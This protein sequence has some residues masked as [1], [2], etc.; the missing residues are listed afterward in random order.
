MDTG[1]TIR[2]APDGPRT[3]FRAY[4]SLQPNRM[5]NGIKA[6]SLILN[7]LARSTTAHRLHGVLPTSLTPIGE[8]T[9]L[10]LFLGKQT[11]GHRRDLE[12]VGGGLKLDVRPANLPVRVNEAVLRE[13]VVALMDA[14][15][16]AASPPAP[17]TIRGIERETGIEL[18]VA[19]PDWNPRWFFQQVREWDADR[20]PRSL[21]R[22]CWDRLGATFFVDHAPP[23]GSRV[24]L[25][26]PKRPPVARFRRSPA[27]I[28]HETSPQP[29]AG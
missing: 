6:L 22:I 18:S 21:R 14:L 26:L 1:G 5:M 28:K 16:P 3:E 8:P 29:L 13:V 25:L 2:P 20:D 11:I 19:H 9:R 24:G 7:P 15:A 10:A 17:V 23:D 12:F 4:S 27:R